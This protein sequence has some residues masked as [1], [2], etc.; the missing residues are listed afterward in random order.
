MRFGEEARK[1]VLPLTFFAI[2]AIGAAFWMPR[3]T[4][5]SQAQRIVVDNML[6]ESSV[7][8]RPTRSLRG[9]EVNWSRSYVVDQHARDLNASDA[10]ADIGGTFKTMR[11]K[12]GADVAGVSAPPEFDSEVGNEIIRQR[13]VAGATFDARGAATDQAGKNFQT[14]TGLVKT[15]PEVDNKGVGNPDGVLRSSNLANDARTHLPKTSSKA[16]KMQLRV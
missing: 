14:V 12:V 3:R 16:L 13:S 9:D 5:A 6:A 11:S 7:L 1:I 4:T 15:E 8:G 10:K 2:Q